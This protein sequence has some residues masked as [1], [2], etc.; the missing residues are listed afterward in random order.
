MNKLYPILTK[1]CSL[2]VLLKLMFINFIVFF[3]TG[4]HV[5]VKGL[6]IFKVMLFLLHF[7]FLIR[8]HC[9]REMFNFIRSK[10]IKLFHVHKQICQKYSG[11]PQVMS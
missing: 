9:T 6:L 3:M 10:T 5:L 11:T 4:T 1:I 8:V 7:V 2:V